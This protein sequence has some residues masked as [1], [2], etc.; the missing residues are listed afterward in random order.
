MATTSSVGGTPLD[1]LSMINVSALVSQTIAAERTA[2]DALKGNLSAQQ[3]QLA[4]YQKV[5]T[6]FASLQTAAVAIVGS[7]YATSPTW[8]T[9]GVTS[10]NSTVAATAAATAGSGEYRFNVTQLAKSHSLLFGTGVDIS[11]PIATGQFIIRN[12][13]GMPVLTLNPKPPATTSS[14]LTL[15]QVVAAINGDSGAGVRAAM[16][17]VGDGLYRLQ[18]TSKSTGASSEFSVDGLGDLGT[19]TVAQQGQ[20]AKIQFGSNATTDV[21]SSSSNTFSDVFPDVT[22]TVSATTVSDPA[23][24]PFAPAVT[25]TVGDD[26]TTMDSQIQGL[27]DAL[28][29]TT[30][31]L[32]AATHSTASGTGPLAGDTWLRSVPQSFA[33]AFINNSGVSASALGLSID[34]H[35][36][37]SFDATT[38]HAQLASDPTTAKATITEL[39]RQVGAITKVATQPVDGLVVKAIADK[40]NSIDALDKKIAA[41]D[42]KLAIRTTMLTQLY[43]TLN[44]N[45]ATLKSTS[46]WITNEITSLTAKTN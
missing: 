6:S 16:I 7:V 1:N 2:Q 4:A 24:T 25:L 29:A 46:D 32:T 12:A 19:T 5:N 44:A 8:A 41:W 13:S 27:V 23:N 9:S 10:S 15:P 18:L 35:G 21:A 30:T 26:V 33:R 40:Q 22:F 11:T 36:V 17:G 37:M 39:A 34:K 20:D 28:N 45:L 31:D 38:F 14:N 43:S 3:A 42:D